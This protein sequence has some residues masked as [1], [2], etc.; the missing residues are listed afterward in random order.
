MEPVTLEL[1]NAWG[2]ADE[3]IRRGIVWAS[4]P[5]GDKAGR[6]LSFSK[7]PCEYPHMVIIPQSQTESVL[8][9]WV[10]RVEVNLRRGYAL[11]ALVAGDAQVSEI[12]NGVYQRGFAQ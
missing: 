10:N 4:A 2:V 5:L 6:T 12:A 8:T 3:M 1:L 7:L 11:K 9:D